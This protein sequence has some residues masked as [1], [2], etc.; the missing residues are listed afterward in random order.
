MQPATWDLAKY[1]AWK[2]GGRWLLREVG[3]QPLS[4]TLDIVAVFAI[5]A[6]GKQSSV[7]ILGPNVGDP[8][9]ARSGGTPRQECRWLLPA[10]WDG[11]LS[12]LTRGADGLQVY[13]A[14]VLSLVNWSAPQD[15]F[16]YAVLEWIPPPGQ[17]PSLDVG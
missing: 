1:P 15:Q 16:V 14:S 6:A 9:Q 5:G 13:Q 11:K 10:G 8:S 3:W 12:W 17:C 7:F 2:K 4:G